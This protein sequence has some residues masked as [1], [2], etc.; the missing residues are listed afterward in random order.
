M[1]D[2][3][4]DFSNETATW[5]EDQLDTSTTIDCELG[6]LIAAV[7]DWTED[8]MEIDDMVVGLVD[9]GYVDLSVGPHLA[10]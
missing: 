7:S 1:D 10:G 5:L 4:N 9:G 6:S 2:F 3:T 8:E